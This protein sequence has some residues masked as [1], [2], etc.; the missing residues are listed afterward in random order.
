MSRVLTA[1]LFL[2]LHSALGQGSLRPCTTVPLNLS[3]SHEAP[4]QVFGIDICVQ[5][6][7]EVPFEFDHFESINNRAANFMLVSR[8]RQVA[9][10]TVRIALNPNVIQQLPPGPYGVQVVFRSVGQSQ[11]SGAE[12]TVVLTLQPPPAPQ[13]RS[14]VSSASGATAGS[15]GE[16][17]SIRGVSLAPPGV[18]ASYDEI[19]R[20]PTVIAGTSVSFGGIEAPILTA[21]PDRIDTMIPYGVKVPGPVDVVVKRWTQSSAPF[22]I[23][24]G[25]TSPAIFNIQDL[26]Y[27]PNTAENP[28]E[29]GSFVILYATGA[30]AWNPPVLDNEVSAGPTSFTAKPL[31]LSIGG[32][33]ARIY[34]AGSAP[35]R[36]WGMQQI[37]AF[38]PTGIDSG[39]QPVVLKIGENDNAAQQTVL[40]VK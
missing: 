19:G 30:G 16:L 35:Y 18:Q 33:P 6:G 31:V 12:R 4:S 27:S 2:C 21:T 25:D 15:P 1:A 22:S 20:Y 9:P 37:I 10:A 11:P 28:V 32:Q 13:V 17:V 40:W 3:V 29:K 5:G 36:L 14:V 38:V 7:S 24:L 34:Y 26:G 8:S 23:R 39:A